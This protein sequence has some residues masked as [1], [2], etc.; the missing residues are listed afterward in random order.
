[1]TAAAA[2]FTPRRTGRALAPILLCAALLWAAAAR[3]RPPPTP[4]GVTAWGVSG[5]VRVAW[6]SAPGA[7]YRV[8]RA[9]SAAGPYADVATTRDT[10]VVDRALAAGETGFYV[11]SAVGPAGE[12]PASAPVEA[13]PAPDLG[14]LPPEPAGL[15]RVGLNVWF[16]SDRDGSLAFVDAARHARPWERA[17]RGEGPAPVDALGWPTADAAT[18]FFS[19]PAARTNGTYRL[20]LRGQAEVAL[21]GSEGAVTGKAYD[22]AR[23]TTTADVT[24]TG[25]GS[26]SRG[27][28][29]TDTRRTPA[30]PTGSGFTDLRLF[31]PGDPADGSVVFTAPFLVALRRASVVRMMDWTATNRNLV[32]RWSERTTPRHASRRGPGYLGAGAARVEESDA[33]VAL[34]HQIQLC[35]ALHADCWINVPVL[36]DDD[37][38]RRLARALRFG[39]DGAEPYAGPRADPAYPPLD[40][41]LRLYVEVGNEVWNGADGFLGFP[42]VQDAVA[43]LPA[44]HPLRVPAA[45]GPLDLVWR[46]P[47]WRIAAVSDVFREQYGDAAM[48]SRIRPVLMAKQGN[49]AGTLAAAL[50][51]LEAHGRRQSPP[52]EVRSY[53]YAAG[54]SAYYHGDAWPMRTP[55]D[56]AEFFAPGNHPSPADVRDMAVD[57]V[58]AASHGL[59][60][61]AYEGGPSLD[62]FTRPQAEAVNLDP[63][64]QEVVVRTHDAWSAGGG[65]LLVYYT[66]TGPASW[67]FTPDLAN[68]ATPKLAALDALRTRPRA[69]V[70]LGPELPGRMIPVADAGRADGRIRS[71]TDFPVAVGGEGCLGGNDVGEWVAVPGHADAAFTGRLTV[72]GRAET[73]AAV[74]VS[75][76]GERR[77]VVTLPAGGGIHES[78]PLAA[79]MP[80]GLVVIRLD[81]VDA[82]FTLCAV[83]VR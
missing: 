32:R 72:S 71:G 35:N 63:R 12:G 56:P 69:A 43:R 67:E 45:P 78:T 33:G 48:M 52:R 44:D 73:E 50:G 18:V 34:E 21:L 38:V 27:L 66:L 51:W 75:V 19:G 29:L 58:W 8:R 47:A 4:A 31:R 79:E 23:N 49:G 10:S 7:A 74:A 77:G 22:P 59:A 80:A 53:V 81:A 2:R 28:A 64:M 83:E 17:A 11:V 20:V 62:G 3:Q 39:T 41:G 70:R 9:A 25:S 60:H 5:G 82:T 6:A 57:S 14:A 24:F 76:N 16:L 40:P 55:G 36:A 42:V 46:H 68:L 61:V 26:G 37:Y 30:S 15:N 65:D 1:M 13:A 54:G